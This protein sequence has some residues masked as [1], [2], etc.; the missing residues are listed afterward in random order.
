MRCDYCAPMGRS[1][2]GRLTQPF[3]T[4]V[5]RGDRVKPRAPQETG[6]Q[7]LQFLKKTRHATAKPDTRR[8]PQPVAWLDDLEACIARRAYD[9]DEES[10]GRDSAGPANWLEAVREALSRVL[11]A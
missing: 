3:S 4:V 8:G 7:R 9:L 5:G 6:K 1:F 11:P 2:R 10:G